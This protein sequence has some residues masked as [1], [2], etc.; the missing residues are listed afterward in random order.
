MDMISECVCMPA[1]V[2][3][4]GQ[5][6]ARMAAKRLEL[7]ELCEDLTCNQMDALLVVARE[8]HATGV[9]CK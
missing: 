5:D 6:S 7:L 3:L 1:D 2:L 9:A 4:H 8:F